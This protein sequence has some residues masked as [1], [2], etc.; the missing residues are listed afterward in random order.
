MSNWTYVMGQIIVAPM[1]RTQNEKEYILKT[2]LDHLP[3]VTGSEEDMQVY[4]YQ[5]R[6][7]DTASSHDEFGMMTDKAIH[8]NGYR[9]R[10]MGMYR[11]S[12]YYILSIK[13][14]LRDRTYEE[15][16]KE[17]IR[18]LSR[19]SKR[20]MVDDILVKV[21]GYSYKHNRNMRWVCSNV[22]PF[23]EMVNKKNILKHEAL[24]KYCKKHRFGLAI[25]D[26]DYYSFEDLKNEKVSNL[27]QNRFIKFVKDNKQLTFDECS[28]F[29]EKYHLTDYQLCYIIWKNRKKHLVYNQR[30]IKYI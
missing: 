17:F 26:S 23:R 29:K 10:K 12:S 27:I 5:D 15:T 21:C 16:V 4:I 18:W 14:E 20:C 13:G 22:K 19:L 9:S 7:Y 25:I 2:V 24:E 1:G 28:I 8:Y 3:L 11:S 30:L 6:L